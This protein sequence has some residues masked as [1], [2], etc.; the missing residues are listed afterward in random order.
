MSWITELGNRIFGEQRQR[1]QRIRGSGRGSGH[2]DINVTVGV[3][4][5]AS[6]GVNAT[7][8]TNGTMEDSY[9]QHEDEVR[10][11]EEKVRRTAFESGQVTRE[12]SRERDVWGNRD[13]ESWR[14]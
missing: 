8:K 13:I 9:R 7:A 3:D 5:D 10:D 11:L 2:V 12:I 14:E 4:V 1:R 6:A